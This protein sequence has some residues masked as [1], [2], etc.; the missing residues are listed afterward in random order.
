MKREESAIILHGLEAPDPRKDAGEPQ[1]E[2]PYLR[3]YVIRSE[4]WCHQVTLVDLG[5]PKV[6]E[7]HGS[8]LK[9]A[10]SRLGETCQRQDTEHRPSQKCFWGC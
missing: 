2:G 1:G 7:L 5:K 4:L 9:Q 6:A 10:T 8:I 3:C